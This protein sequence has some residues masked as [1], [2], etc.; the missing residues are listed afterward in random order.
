MIKYFF[1]FIKHR[2]DVFIIKNNPELQ[3]DLYKDYNLIKDLIDNSIKDIILAV[4]F[5]VL[6]YLFSYACSIYKSI[7]L[8]FNFSSIL[9]TNTLYILFVG[10]ISYRMEIKYKDS[11]DKHNVLMFLSSSDKL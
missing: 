7:L 11:E 5:F 6:S 10:L 1:V 9:I 2:L 4:E 8:D 3:D